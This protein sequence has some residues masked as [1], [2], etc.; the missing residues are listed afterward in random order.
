M[1]RTGWREA[2]GIFMLAAGLLALLSV[3]SYDP[4]DLS[5]F[6]FPPSAQTGNLAGIVG[7]WTATSLF[8]GLGVAGWLVPWALLGLGGVFLFRREPG[9]GWKALCV[10]AAILAL[11]ALVELQ[12]GWW[13][14]AVARLNCG[15]PGGVVGHLLGPRL[16][17]RGLG[18]VGSAFLLVALVLGLGAAV[19]GVRLLTAGRAVAA[20]AAGLVA[21]IQRQRDARRDRLEKLERERL[22]IERD[23]ERLERMIRK[24]EPK[25]APADPPGPA[26]APSFTVSG[27]PVADIPPS[28]AA[29][30]PPEADEEFTP[31]GEADV[32]EPVPAPAPARAARPAPAPAKGGDDPDEVEMP[33][34]PRVYSLPPKD[35]LP[36]LPE[37]HGILG[38]SDIEHTVRMLEGTLQEFGIEAKVTNV[39]RG[40]VVTLFEL[41]PAKGVRVERIAAMDKNLALVMKAESIR[42]QAPVPGKGV[43]GIEVPNPSASI[44][45]LRE[46]VDSPEWSSG[47]ARLPLA[48]GKDVS[49]RVIIGDLADMPHLL[50]AGATGSGKSVC[51]NSILAG[52]LLSRTPDQLRLMLVDPKIVE[53][54]QYASLPHLV[55]PVITDAKK[56]GFGLRWAIDEMERRYTLFARAGVRNVAAFNARARQEELFAEETDE[57][58][59]PDKLP[60]IV[61]VVDELADLMLTAKA[62]IENHIARLTQKSRATGIHLILATQRPSVNVITGTIKANIPARI[63]FQVAQGNDSRTILDAMGAENL[64][65]KGDMLYLPP[66]SARLIRAQGTFTADAEIARIVQHLKDQGE[67]EFLPGAHEKVEKAGGGGGSTPDLPDQDE[68]DD[69]VAQAV[70]ILRQTRRASVSSL[71]RRLRIGYNRAARLMDVLEERGYVG[72]PR[73]SDPREILIDIEG[74]VPVNQEAGAP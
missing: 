61:I 2:A 44:V 38:T 31:V 70:E 29:P 66:G 65:G 35:M 23:R 5:L 6:Q 49:G 34:L 1:I 62:E 48:L 64:L 54:T 58:P 26:E 4:A 8:L 45:Y 71:Q 72:P 46:I 18:T 59:L 53:F 52:L 10:A 63:A 22:K 32:E 21:W 30:A 12:A 73:G 13:S 39:E 27:T 14:G 47:K 37:R 60:Y 16:L 7:A 55:V 15:S 17:V 56:V 50:I 42:I 41:L 28:P 68:D 36:P 11:A 24:A 57:E 20:G 33:E 40:P 25:T 74:D 51:M 19:F 69:L 43:V 9:N 67:P 3:G